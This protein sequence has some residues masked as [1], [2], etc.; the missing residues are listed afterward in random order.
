MRQWK[1]AQ[2]TAFGLITLC[3]LV[4][5]FTHLQ[6]QEAPKVPPKMAN[7]ANAVSETYEDWVLNCQGIAK[8]TECAMSQVLSQQNGQRVLTFSISP[9]PIDGVQRGSFIMPFGLDLKSGVT[10][11]L[12]DKA[13]STPFAFSTCIPAGCIV[14]LSW[15]VE[16]YNALRAANGLKVA[17]KSIAGEA[18]ELTVSLK[19]LS[20]AG[21]RA[22]EIL[23]R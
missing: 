21:K 6:A 12:D 4:S 7:G 8:G 2:K 9:V 13:P 20:A 11:A 5:S 10:I 19:G 3:M 18:F 14:P 22:A 16:Q 15:S 23:A 1:N 17:A